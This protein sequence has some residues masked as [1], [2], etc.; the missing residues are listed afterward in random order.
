MER[1]RFWVYSSAWLGIAEEGEV[2]EPVWDG[3]VAGAEATGAV[4]ASVGRTLGATDTT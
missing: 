2:V 4:G 3:G 1:Q